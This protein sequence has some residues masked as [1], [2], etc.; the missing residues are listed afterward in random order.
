MNIQR[1]RARQRGM[2]LLEVLI[3]I[4]IFAIGVLGMVKMQAVATANAVNSEDRATAALLANDLISELWTTQSVSAPS[5]YSTW[6]T[7][8]SNALRDGKG[9]LTPSATANQATVTIQWSREL[10]RNVTFGANSGSDSQ[11][12]ATYTT[13]VVIQ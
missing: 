1:R 3:G 2:M 9:T 13:Q 8:V 12:T 6:Q 4:L 7:R 11:K 5:D 10:G